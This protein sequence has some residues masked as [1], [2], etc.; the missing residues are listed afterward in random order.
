[1][2]DETRTRIVNITD[3]ADGDEVVVTKGTNVLRAKVVMPG[4]TRALD[5]GISHSRPRLAAFFDAGYVVEKVTS[6]PPMPTEPGHYKDARGRDWLRT[7]H[8]TGE[9]WIAWDGGRFTPERAERSFG[10]FTRVVPGPTVD[11]GPEKV[12]DADGDAWTRNP[13]GTYTF[14]HLTKTLDMIKADHGPVKT[15]GAFL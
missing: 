14:R 11:S 8:G 10:P 7:T 4:S 15:E 13:D 6:K 2:T 5:I 9:N 3:I 12:I 1:M